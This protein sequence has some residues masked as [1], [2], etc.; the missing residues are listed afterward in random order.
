MNLVGQNAIPAVFPG[1]YYS[2]DV[3]VAALLSMAVMWA[4]LIVAVVSGSVVHA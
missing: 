4:D 3:H 2:T 1:P